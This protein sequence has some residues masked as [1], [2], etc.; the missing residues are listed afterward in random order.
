[1]MTSKVIA[2]ETRMESFTQ[3]LVSV[4][5]NLQKNEANMFE[6]KEI[7][8][9]ESLELQDRLNITYAYASEL[10][11]DQ[12]KLSQEYATNITDIKTS[13]ER[14]NARISEVNRSSDLSGEFAAKIAEIKT[15]IEKQNIRILEV[16][17]SSNQGTKSYRDQTIMQMKSLNETITNIRQISESVRNYVTLKSAEIAQINTSV[18]NQQ[19]TI[20]TLQRSMNNMNE[21][22]IEYNS[23]QEEVETKLANIEDMTNKSY[24]I[25]N[26]RIND[27][28]S[29]M[30]I[31][32]ENTISYIDVTIN[33][34]KN[35]LFSMLDQ[36][37]ISQNK[38][39]I[40]NSLCNET[41]S[42]L[43]IRY[44]SMNEGIVQTQRNFNARFAKENQQ[45]RK[46]EEGNDL[47]NQ[48]LLSLEDIMHSE[49]HDIK[50]FIVNNT[51][52]FQDLKMNLTNV[53]TRMSY[54][55]SNISTLN[56]EMN[57][58]NN[59]VSSQSVDVVNI[60]LDYI[61][62]SCT[63]SMDNFHKNMT[64]LYQRFTN[65][66]LK[67]NE[68]QNMVLT[69][70]NNFT[71]SLA[72]SRNSLN[73]LQNKIAGLERIRWSQQSTM[74]SIQT[75]VSNHKSA[76]K[77]VTGSLAESRNSL[78][79]LQNRI[80][81]FE[82]NRGSQQ[83]TMNSIQTWVSNHKSAYNNF[84]VS[85]AESRN[86]LNSLQNKIAGLER[87]RGSQQS[88][89]NSIQTWVSNH[90]SACKQFCTITLLFIGLWALEHY[91][92]HKSWIIVDNNFTVSLAESRNSLN[93]L[94]NKIAGLERN[95]GSQQSTMNSIQT[96]VSNHKSAYKNVT[97]SL[98]ESRN[99]L[100]RLQ[101][102]IASLERNRGSQ[103]STMNSIQTWVSNHKSAC[104]RSQLHMRFIVD[105]RL[106]RLVN[107][108]S[109]YGRLEVNIDGEGWGNVC[110]DNFGSSDANVV[111][112]QLGYSSGIA[113][114][115]AYYGQG[116]LDIIMD[117]VDCI[118]SEWAIQHCRYIG[119]AKENCAH[120]EDVGVS[121]S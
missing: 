65:V 15:S 8:K 64:D 66:T 46:L 1:M 57:S 54:F 76:Y 74:N 111:C 17:E 107:G 75:W 81:S 16:N 105:K 77:N 56:R 5:Q 2:I 58:L 13:L 45:L 89:M 24:T 33:Q 41:T 117:D 87:N 67:V 99:S 10:V 12:R 113:R 85:L 50:Q 11:N 29:K 98:A 83:S 6:L 42:D 59:T 25:I 61:N 49:I 30:E 23:K 7:I 102:R 39:W 53:E 60:K 62:A 90:K 40:L 121:C 32:V 27:L 73:S 119:K 70:D 79:S 48:S 112:K 63:T 97:G 52:K 43:F 115:S 101:N 106:V 68:V 93:S 82:R 38:L 80:A 78:N 71:V 109:S 104:Q 96:W 108:G 26:G 94:Q 95:R 91:E 9:T 118:G 86:S 20:N 28:E 72:E 31:N 92:K 47:L 37:Y 35:E 84:T 21:K 88:T 3:N 114:A 18:L 103:Q 34:T 4:Q 51:K 116:S 19:Y 55:N 100:K 120:S 22:L 110:D 14:Q 69:K 44:E 36:M